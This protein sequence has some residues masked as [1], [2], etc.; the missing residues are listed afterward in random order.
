[1]LLSKEKREIFHSVIAKCIFICT[2]SG[3]DGIPTVGVLVGR[4]REINQSDC[5]KGRRLVRYFSCTKDL[6]LVLH[7]D[8]L[9]ICNWCVDAAFAVH[10][11]FKSHSG[12]L[13]MMSDLGG[14]MASG[15]TKQ[16]L[17]THL[18]TEAEL[19]SSDNFLTN[20]I[21]CKNVLGE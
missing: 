14:G 9:K 19:V 13:V 18:S 4:V 21:W 5:E 3:T 15:S 2:R 8:G 1:M 7:Y 16:K 17:N 11:D 12:G 6:H 20:I 10:L